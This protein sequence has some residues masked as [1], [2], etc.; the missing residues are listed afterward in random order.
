M[1]SMNNNINQN[2]FEQL[3]TIYKAMQ[4]PTQFMSSL[5]QNNPQMQPIIAMMQ[6]GMTPEQIVRSECQKRNIDVNELLKQIQQ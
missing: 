4:N 3:K 6:N 5:A 1:F 2:S